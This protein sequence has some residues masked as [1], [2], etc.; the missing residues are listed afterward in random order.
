MLDLDAGKYAAFVWPAYAITAAVFVLLIV[1]A[2]AHAR[3]WRRR[4]EELARK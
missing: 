4:A 3:R 2:L 1:G